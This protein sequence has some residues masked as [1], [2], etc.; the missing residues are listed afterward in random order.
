MAKK[1]SRTYDY[2]DE[3]GTL[4]Y[5]N[6]RLDRDAHPNAPKSLPRRP[7]GKGGWIWDLKD[8]RRVLYRLPELL[9]SPK[10]DFV[11]V[12]EGEPDT[13]RLWS[14]GLPATTSGSAT[15]WRPEFAE[16]F[17]GRLVC[18]LPDHDLAGE[19]Y[20]KTIA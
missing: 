5:Q 1:I 4:L 18:I 6:C 14:F 8:V 12:C 2:T 17:R 16:Y 3:A 9:Q 13:D 15:S 7:D 19:R 10:Q 20:A 11:F